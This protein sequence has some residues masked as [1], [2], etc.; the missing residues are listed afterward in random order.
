MTCVVSCVQLHLYDLVAVRKQQVGT[1]QPLKRTARS[2]LADAAARLMLTTNPA[3]PMGKENRLAVGPN[4][5]LNLPIHA[6]GQAKARHNNSP[7]AATGEDRKRPS[8]RFGSDTH[9][10]FSGNAA[11]PGSCDHPWHFFVPCCASTYKEGSRETIETM[12]QTAC[13]VPCSTWDMIVSANDAWGVAT[14]QIHLDPEASSL[15]DP[16]NACEQACFEHHACG[17]VRQLD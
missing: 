4:V 5:G 6:G 11:S 12:H 1:S 15:C 9:S 16:I 13:L 7:L 14:K 3:G 17:W 10:L 2:S 8:L